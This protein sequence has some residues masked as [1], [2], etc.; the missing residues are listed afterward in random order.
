MV[1]TNTDTGTPGAS[2]S[3]MPP[4]AETSAKTTEVAIAATGATTTR[5]AAAAG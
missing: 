5:T 2:D 4:T 3:R 1:A